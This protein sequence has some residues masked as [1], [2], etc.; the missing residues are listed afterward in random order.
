MG[1]RQ[2]Y[3][4]K[5]NDGA[6]QDSKSSDKSEC[7]V[8][9]AV[10]STED[11][12]K[13]KCDHRFC[14]SCVIELLKG[15]LTSNCPIC[16][17]RI[18]AF[19]TTRISTG[20]ALAERPTTIFGGVY[21]QCDTEGLASYHFNDGDSYISYSAAPPFWRLDDGSPPPVKKPF[22]NASYDASTRTFRAAVDWS[23]VNFNGDAKWIY[24]IVFSEDF[25]SIESGEVLSYGAAG[26]KRHWH[27][28]EQD[29]FYVRQH[30]IN[31]DQ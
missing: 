10:Q 12:L 5:M 26:E 30:Q 24:R 16:R 14:R 22:L 27:A 2:L 19:D 3:K 31:L 8:C 7:P 28:Y 13:T 29:L 18:S 20:Q 25:A 15:S 11:L 9:L 17:Q 23:H 21:V 6:Q 4:L 1:Q